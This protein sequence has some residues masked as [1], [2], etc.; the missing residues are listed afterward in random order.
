[1]IRQ[2]LPIQFGSGPSWYR[3][4]VNYN[5]FDL[6]Q[7]NTTIQTLNLVGISPASPY[8]QTNNYQYPQGSLILY[9]RVKA[10][11]A[12]VATSLTHA[13]VDVG[14]PATVLNSAGSVITPPGSVATAAPHAING[15]SGAGTGGITYDALTAVADN[16]FAAGAAANLCPGDA[17]FG[18]T[19]SVTLVGANWTAVTA[20]QIALDLEAI[21][22]SMG[23]LWTSQYLNNPSPGNP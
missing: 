14:Y 12:F 15:G 16:V 9:F 5:D 18:I 3:W 13:W 8:N 7:A 1:M 21:T 2:V 20:G 4:L 6:T 22:P 10:L 19:I 17:A 23:E 11:T